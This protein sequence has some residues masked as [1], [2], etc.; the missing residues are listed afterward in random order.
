VGRP[1]LSSRHDR[2]LRGIPHFGQVSENSS[3]RRPLPTFAFAG[4]EGRHVLHDDVGGSKLANDPGEL[5]PKTRAG[6]IEP[7]SSPG[8]GEVLAGEATADEVDR[9]EVLRSDPADV[10]ESLRSWEVALEDRPAVGVLLDLPC[11]P[12][13]AALEAEVEPAD[14]RE[15]RPDIHPALPSWDAPGASK[16]SIQRAGS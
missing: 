10:L 4:E 3:D 13:P 11:D 2:P 5:G 7:G 8:T 12:H 14:A 6:A 1:E 9:R 16:T 15:E